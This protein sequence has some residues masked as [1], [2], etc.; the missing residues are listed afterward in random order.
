[1]IVL[2]F[3]HKKQTGTS[4][5]LLGSMRKMS[6]FL[7]VVLSLAALGASACSSIEKHSNDEPQV[8]AAPDTVTAMLADAADRASNALQ[9]LASIEST[10]TPATN[11]GPVGNAPPELRRSITVNWI[12]PVEPIATTLAQRAGYEFLT[13][14][15]PPPVPVVVSIDAENRPVIDILRDI[16]LQLGVRGDV[17]VDSQSRVVEIHYPPNTGVGG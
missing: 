3:R 12:G 9:T 13:I 17:K 1:M 5:G 8:V 15:T 10:R 4:T 2:S 11:V 16:G 7:T 6:R 14:G